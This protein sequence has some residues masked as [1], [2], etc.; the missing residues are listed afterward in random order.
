MYLC[1]AWRT[2]LGVLLNVREV[3]LYCSVAVAKTKGID[4]L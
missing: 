3:L 4:L 1:S 2:S